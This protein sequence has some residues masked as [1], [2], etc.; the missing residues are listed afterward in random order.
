MLNENV[1]LDIQPIYQ[2]NSIIG[3]ENIDDALASILNKFNTEYILDIVKNSLDLKFRLYDGQLPNIIYGYEQNFQELLNNF[4]NNKDIIIKKRN[5]LYMDI[6]QYLC[7]YYDLEL[8]I[9]TD[10]DIYESAFVLYKFLVSDFTSNLILLFTNYIIKENEELVKMFDIDFV[11]NNVNYNYSKK[12]FIN[13]DN[14]AVIHS[15][16][17]SVIYNIC[18]FDISLYNILDLIYGDKL[19]VE[20][21]SS[22]VI[23]KSN[24]FKNHFVNHVLDQ[25][26]GPE[27]QTMI[28]LSLQN[29]YNNTLN[30]GV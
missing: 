10:N 5:E 2:Y 21:I 4:E 7:Y 1:K 24:M 12:I 22:L 19:L 9:N 20:K 3:S 18:N 8:N 14:I 6:I 25:K 27:L 26:F 11:K 15:Q 17:F 23:D 13:N 16:L 29:V 30:G 28:K